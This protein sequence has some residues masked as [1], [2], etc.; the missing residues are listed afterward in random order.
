MGSLMQPVV[1]TVGQIAATLVSILTILTAVWLAARRQTR[2][3]DRLKG[4]QARDLELKEALVEALKKLESVGLAQ[5]GMVSD[6]RGLSERFR[7]VEHRAFY[8]REGEP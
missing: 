3:E 4:L 6:V 7:L 5:A 8:R 1:L 2:I